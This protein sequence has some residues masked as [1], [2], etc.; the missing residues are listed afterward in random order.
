[1]KM[2]YSKFKKWK[3]YTK[4]FLALLKA[5]LLKHQVPF[6]LEIQIT[7]V[8]NLKC[9]YCY[10]ALETIQTTDFTL[11]EL[12]SIIDEFHAMGTRV[13]RILGGEPLVRK[14]IGEIIRYLKSKDIFIEM[15][16]NGIFIE[17]WVDDLKFLDILQISIDGDEMANDAVRGEGTYKKIIAGLE[18]AVKAGL[19]VRI[20]GVFNKLSIE[21]GKKSPVEALA[22]LSRKYDIPFNFC[23]Y[24]LGEEGK[25]DP[26][27][28]PTY[29]SFR[30]TMKYHEELMALKDKG[31]K[32]FNSSEAMKQIINWANPDKDVLYDKDIPGLPDYYS[33]CRAGELYCFLDTDGALYPCVPLWKKGINIKEIGI[34]KAWENVQE[35]RRKAGCFACV[36]LGDIEFSK[37]LSLKP[38]ALLNTFKKV[39]TLWKGK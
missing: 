33:K 10:A 26:S 32:F 14:D 39:K 24:V 27:A 1:M 8:C 15:A 35:E 36:S 4:V 18:T 11:E 5:N 30:D 19:P 31:Y 23:Q 29:V 34:K 16:T 22:E 38:S 12:K 2:H 28:N 6:M 37:T 3:C 9:K 21:A 20:H 25:K 17:R 13:V 7:K